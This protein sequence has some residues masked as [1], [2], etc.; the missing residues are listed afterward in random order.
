MNYIRFSIIAFSLFAVAPSVWAQ[1]AEVK[2]TSTKYVT[3]PEDGVKWI[4]GAFN[5]QESWV[6]FLSASSEPI[7]KIRC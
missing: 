1:P 5:A 7:G 6:G 3:S 2:A 4:L